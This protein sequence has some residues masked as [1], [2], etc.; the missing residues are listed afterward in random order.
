MNSILRLV[1]ARLLTQ[2]VQNVVSIGIY[3]ANGALALTDS[4]GATNP[5]LTPLDVTDVV[6]SLVAD[7]FMIRVD[8]TWHMFFEVM[9]WRSTAPKGE[10]GHATST[11]GLGWHYDRIVLAEPFHLS[12]P[13]VFRSG[14]DFYMIP[15]SYR[16]GTVR[17]YRAE[18][19]PNRW[20]F[21][22]ALLTGAK[23]KDSSILSR[24]GRWWLYTETSPRLENDTLRLFHAANLE[25]PWT[26]HPRSPIVN[27]DARIARPGGRV[28]SLRDRVIRLA[29]DCSA[30]Y[31]ESVRAL[32]ILQLTER[33]YHEEELATEPLV[34]GTGRGWNGAGMHHVDPHPVAGG[35]WLASVDGWYRVK[36]LRQVLDWVRDAK[37]TRRSRRET[38]N[39][40]RAEVDVRASARTAGIR[41]RPL[42]RP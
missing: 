24:D 20:V 42:S 21:V 1:S 36:G 27:G 31:G 7:P 40:V 9:A 6:A 39:R 12:Y 3:H 25:G 17:L 33:E 2:A 16:A 38:M 14:S 26:E 13:Y 19:F 35:E 37:S 22:K 34:S 29:Q 11:D 32:E 10:I 5:V 23:F 15:E 4:A 30:T 8:G 28:V 18:R 41:S